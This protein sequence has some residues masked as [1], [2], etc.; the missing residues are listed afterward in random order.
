MTISSNGAAEVSITHGQVWVTGL[1][2]SANRARNRLLT[3]SRGTDGL[4][5]VSA[6]IDTANA[7]SSTGEGPA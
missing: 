4:T 3:M 5:P 1:S 7:A 6:A 2:V